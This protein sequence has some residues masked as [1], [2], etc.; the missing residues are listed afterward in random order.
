MR[1]RGW[2]WWGEHNA[3]VW[4]PIAP[5]LRRAISRRTP[6]RR[7]R[8][9]AQALRR[10][11][12]LIRPWHEPRA[13]HASRERSRTSC[14]ERIATALQGAT[15]GHRSQSPQLDRSRGLPPIARMLAA[16]CRRGARRLSPKR[17]RT[18]EGVLRGQTCAAGISC[19]EQPAP[20]AR[21][22]TPASTSPTVPS[23]RTPGPLPEPAP[24]RR[25]TK[26]S[27]SAR[28]QYRRGSRYR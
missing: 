27:T 5:R 6:A 21:S 19:G 12:V 10:R 1:P 9:P 2:R 15:A 8:R 16:A 3:T 25:G 14:A 22:R 23:R 13:R 7:G 17:R 26:E 20:S 18:P 24:I 11:P 4:L 28:W